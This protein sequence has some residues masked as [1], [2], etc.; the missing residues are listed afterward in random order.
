ML[1][2]REIVKVDEERA[3]AKVYCPNCGHSLLLGDKDKKIC[4]HCNHYVFR[5]E[6]TEKKYRIMEKINK[7]RR[8]NR[9]EIN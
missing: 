9:T 8:E 3:R 5:D 1:S 6:E 7:L 2:F 4:S